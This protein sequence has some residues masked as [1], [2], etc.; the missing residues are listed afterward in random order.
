MKLINFFEGIPRFILFGI[1]IL[2][3]CEL[4]YIKLEKK[5]FIKGLISFVFIMQLTQ[6][7]IYYLY[8]ND[9]LILRDIFSMVL[10]LFMTFFMVKILYGKIFHVDGLFTYILS[11]IILGVTNQFV[12][13]IGVD[14]YEYLTN[15]YEDPLIINYIFQL[16]V[17]LIMFGAYRILLK[18]FGNIPILLAFDN[19]NF[20]ILFIVFEMTKDILESSPIYYIITGDEFHGK[21]YKYITFSV[22]ILIGLW[23]VIYGMKKYFEKNKKLNETIILQQETYINSLESI[24]ED[25]RKYNHDYKNLLTGALLQAKYGDYDG[26]RLYLKDVFDEFEEKLGK[27]ISKNTQLKKIKSNEVKGLLLSKISKMEELKIEFHLEVLNEVDRINM[28]TTDLVRCL[29]ILLDNAIEEVDKQEERI[30]KLVILQEEKVTTIMV[31]NPVTEKVNIQNIYQEGFSTKEDIRGLG[32]SNYR[33]IVENYE[34]IVRETISTEREF[35]QILK[36]A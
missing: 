32:L 36:I 5:V 25:I 23:I 22:H 24:Q 13:T 10:Y 18:K 7:G 9:Q 20:K 33:E 12:V 28:K 27:Q 2:K 14:I 4:M 30:I 17:F 19:K 34:N 15:I 21:I 35:N 26:V 3:Y 16:T 1:I 6:L 29:G 8:Y 31:K 11:S